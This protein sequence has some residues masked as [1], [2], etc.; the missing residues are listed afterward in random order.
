MRAALRSLPAWALPA[1]MGAVALLVLAVIL[2]GAGRTGPITTPVVV[3]SP[4]SG[5]SE[6][7][8]GS[9]VPDFSATGFDGKPVRVSADRGKVLLIN[10][11]ASW[12]PDCRAEFPEIQHAYTANRAAGF[13]VVGVDAFDPG[14]GRAF[15]SGLGATFPAVRDPFVNGA[16]GPVA[17][18]FGLSG[19]LPVSFFVD[20]SGKIHQI[21][22]GRI[23]AKVIA[24][25]LAAMG[26]A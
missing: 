3:S 22:P 17:R 4:E 19:G 5:S 7:H 9:T 23:D 20:R 15:Y 24:Q 14:D 2:L 16:R 6:L 12:C 25:E 1:A 11:F 21:Y 8:R 13:D 10:F 26:I 18:A